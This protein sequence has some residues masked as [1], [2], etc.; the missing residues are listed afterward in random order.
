M[1]NECTSRRDKEC[2]RDY[3]YK[4]HC[5]PRSHN[6]P[7]LCECGIRKHHLSVDIPD[8]LAQELYRPKSHSFDVITNKSHDVS[9]DVSHDVSFD[10][11]H[12]VSYELNTPRSTASC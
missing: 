11:S 4:L 3:E 1:G 12:D 7:C 6:L 8:A 10:V 5:I 9:F 2:K